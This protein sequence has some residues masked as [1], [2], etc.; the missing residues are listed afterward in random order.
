MRNCLLISSLFLLA[1]SSFAAGARDV[2]SW[3]QEV[4][5]RTLPVYSGKVPA[6]VLLE[7][8]RVSM[9]SAGLMT[10]KERRAIKILTH[11]G[12]RDADA[13]VSYSKGGRRIKAFHAWLVTP[14]GF[15][16][17]YEKGSIADIGAFEEMELY[18][19]IRFQ[20]IKA[21]NPEV[22]SV[23][24]YEAEVE[25]KVL[26]A[27]DEYVFQSNLPAVESRY[28][29]TVPQG[30]SV[31]GVMFNHAPVD[32]VVDG[33][34]YLWKLSDLPFH[35]REAHSPDMLGLVPWLAI[36][37]LPPAGTGG[38][39]GACFRSWADVSRWYASLSAGQDEVTPEL[40]AK[41]HELIAR[42]RT[43]YERIQAI[44][45]YVQKVKYVAIEMDLVH[46]GGYKPHAAN[47]VFRKQYGDCKDKAN[48]MRS[49]L[50]A[51]GI[52][53]Y[54]VII[55]SGDRTHVR[56]EWPSP[57]QFN[58]MI[59][60]VKVPEGTTAST[61]IEV[62]PLGR[63]L[64]FD[65]TSETTPMGDL[66][67][68]EQGSFAALV[69]GDKGDIL[70]MPVIAP[71]ANSTDV[72]VTAEITGGGALKAL[73]SFVKKGQSAA[74]ERAQKLY[75]KPDEYQRHVEEFFAQRIKGVTISKLDSED[76]FRENSFGLQVELG[77]PM[78]G[79]LMQGRLLVFNP[80]VIEP[81]HPV[82]PVNNARTE[83]I[84]LRAENYRKHIHIR[85]PEG[86]TV[87]EMPAPVKQQS[88][89]GQFSLTFEQKAGEL[90]VE[91]ELKTE[92]ATLPPDQYR[93]VKRF[94]DQFRG[95]DHQ[96]AVLVK[97]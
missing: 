44:G 63:V 35:E 92:A 69:A 96:Q 16:K 76:K 23:F 49:L 37:L 29:M 31:K 87:D 75:R 91:E 93:E 9:D 11:E 97:N 47:L 27:Q 62:P 40:A 51:A 43:E 19:D 86:F 52:E 26:F 41:S 20:Q 60:A 14:N 38:T 15:V 10:V 59:I 70:K 13:T 55:H 89:W 42:A 74:E 36:D 57:S 48:L 17:A 77:S 28:A 6:A 56:Q 54:L 30:W 39:M 33:T 66:P 18:N 68:Y 65:P 73:C 53:S 12:K 7:E 78:Y 80:S 50:K 79:Q 88:P 67:W 45:Q 32:P 61:V 22:G 71:E 34:T 72:T 84:I 5:S 64:L 1:C 2:P 95:A 8:Q 25:E 46:G 83:P 4:S 90:V 82:F 58:H 94:F 85:L 24:A 81:T 3:V 21:E